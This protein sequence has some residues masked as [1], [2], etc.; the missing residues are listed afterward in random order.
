MRLCY[1]IVPEIHYPDD[2][3]SEIYY[4]LSLFAIILRKFKE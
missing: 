4:Y 3:I 1:K 2:Y